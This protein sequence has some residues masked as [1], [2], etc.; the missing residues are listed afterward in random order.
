[1]STTD[2]KLDELKEL[3]SSSISSLK[4]S[5]AKSIAALKQSH[6][7]NCKAMGSKLSKLEEDLTAVKSQQEDVTEEA[8]KRARKERP[9]DFNKKG[10]EEQFRFNQQVQ[11]NIAAASRQ[12][13]K[14]DTTDHDKA[15]L[16]KAKDELLEGPYGQTK[17]DPSDRFIEK[18]LGCS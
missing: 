1:M 8:L 18:W 17:N 12:L 5:H 7:E 4:Q 9:L 3:F 10:H 13:G 15:V 14:L 6:E 2:Q 16:E 11:D